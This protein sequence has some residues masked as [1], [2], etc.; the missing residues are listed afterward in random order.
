VHIDAQARNEI[1]GN[2]DF[3]LTMETFVAALRLPAHVDMDQVC[4]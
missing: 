2:R 3:I 1:D 4:K